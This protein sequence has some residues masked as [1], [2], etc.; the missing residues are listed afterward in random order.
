MQPMLQ[1]NATLALPLSECAYI[2]SVTALRANDSG[3]RGRCLRARGWRLRSCDD[4][5][6]TEQGCGPSSD[7]PTHPLAHPACIGHFHPHR[8][9]RRH[10]CHC[11]HTGYTPEPG[12]SGPPPA[13]ACTFHIH[14][15]LLV[16]VQH[17]RHLQHPQTLVPSATTT[18]LPPIVSSSVGSRNNTHEY[19][20]ITGPTQPQ[21]LGQRKPLVRD[22]LHELPGRRSAVDEHEVVR[23]FPSQRAVTQ[24][25]ALLFVILF[26]NSGPHRFEHSLVVFHCKMHNACIVSAPVSRCHLLHTRHFTSPVCR[27][28]RGILTQSVKGT[29]IVVFHL[30]LRNDVLWT[31]LTVT[32]Q[33]REALGIDYQRWLPKLPY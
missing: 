16:Q 15:P 8:R 11:L 5:G 18:S 10:H 31:E 23:R 20:N 6:E 13:S 1:H 19:T 21:R 29:P 7:A 17:R 27:H 26:G 33:E 32:R 25:L 22:N 30:F 14:P 2:Q 12:P 9:G 28:L 4:A 24:T 3:R